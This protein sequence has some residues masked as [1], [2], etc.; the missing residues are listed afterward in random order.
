MLRTRRV[1]DCAAERGISM[2]QHIKIVKSTA[3]SAYVMSICCTY[4]FC[5]RAFTAFVSIATTTSTVGP[6]RPRERARGRCVGVI[7]S[8]PT[9]WMDWRRW[10][11][12]VGA[13]RMVSDRL[14]E[15][16]S[17]RDVE[18]QCFE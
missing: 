18:A 7:L 16:V 12:F 13:V 3:S 15:S 2:D 5:T 10:R 6:L 17:T 14:K 9:D 11:W 4:I 8:V 1:S